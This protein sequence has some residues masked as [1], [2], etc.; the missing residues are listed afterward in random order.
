M[1]DRIAFCFGT[2][3]GKKK[4]GILCNNFWRSYGFIEAYLYTLLRACKRDVTHVISD[5]G[6]RKGTGRRTWRWH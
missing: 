4:E 3:I 2:A 6:W 1:V 5:S